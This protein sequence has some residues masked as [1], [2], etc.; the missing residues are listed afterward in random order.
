[1]SLK[2][3][4]NYLLPVNFWLY[5]LTGQGAN[6]CADASFCILRGLQDDNG[7]YNDPESVTLK[8]M[9]NPDRQV[10][11]GAAG[12]G[13]TILHTGGP[14]VRWLFEC[15]DGEDPVTSTRGLP[16]PEHVDCSVSVR[17]TWLRR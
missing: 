16:A 1:M 10:H 17:R 9:S 4:D 12:N 5:A 14:G 15:E 3:Q 7:G 8:S 11:V 6:F 2:I 13:P